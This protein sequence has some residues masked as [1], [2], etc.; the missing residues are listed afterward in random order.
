G[1]QRDGGERW[2]FHLEAVDQLGGEV[3]RVG[4]RAAVSAGENLAVGEQA[5]GGGFDA[6][7]N[8]AGKSDKRILL[9]ADAVLEL[10][11]NAVTE[12][13][14]GVR[15]ASS[16]AGKSSRLEGLRTLPDDV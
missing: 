10:A 16:K 15:L 4:R 5:L 14:G 11:G 3:L 6:F 8:R 7:G 13:H 2:A 1:R 9:D 12:V